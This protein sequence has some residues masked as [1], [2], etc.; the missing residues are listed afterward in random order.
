MTKEEK[1]EFR[2]GFKFF[3]DDYRAIDKIEAWIENKKKEWQEE[4]VEL[5]Y[6]NGVQDGYLEA[7]NNK[8]K[9]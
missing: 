4:A 9:H 8:E 6:R 1:K 7:R 2:D 5:A 3:V